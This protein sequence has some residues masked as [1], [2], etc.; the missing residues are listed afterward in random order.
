VKAVDERRAEREELVELARSYAAVLAKR[1][2]LVEAWVVGSVARGDF[3]VWSDVDVL[4]VAERL[5]ER[6]PDRFGLLLEGAPPR[7]QP[8]GYTP[9]ELAREER[10]GN[11][12]VREARELGIAVS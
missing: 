9:A 3:N 12:L 8:I 6:A 7:I 1:V 5:P 11:P 10:R 4:V 2:E